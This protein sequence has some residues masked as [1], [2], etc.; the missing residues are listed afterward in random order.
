MNLAQALLPV[1]ESLPV[2]HAR[3]RWSFDLLNE[4]FGHFVQG[5]FRHRKED[6]QYLTPPEVVAAMIDIGLHDLVRDYRK[7]RSARKLLI[8]DP[9]C[10]VGSFLAGAY[11]QAGRQSFQGQALAERLEFFGQDK[12][13]RMVRMARVNMQCFSDAK[14][15]IRQGNSVDPE[16]LDDITGSVDLLLTNPPFGASFDRGKIVDGTKPDLAIG[17][18]RFPI[19]SE[20]QKQQT[21][22]ARIDSEFLMFDRSLSLLREGGRMLIVVPD[23]VV[24]ADGFAAAFRAATEEFAELIAVIDLPAEAFAQAGTRTKTSVVYVR[25]RQNPSLSAVSSNTAAGRFASPVFMATVNDLGFRVTSRAGASVKKQTGIN[26]L[27]AVVECYQKV[28]RCRTGSLKGSECKT[29]S[30]SPSVSLIVKSELLN[31]RW[32][33]SFY[34]A[35]R[36]GALAEIQQLDRRQWDLYTL[37]ELVS[38][39]PERDRRVDRSDGSAMI[40]V[41]HVREDGFLDLQ[42]VQ[43]YSPTSGCV[44]CQA[45]DVLISRINPRIVRICVVPDLGR[46][47]GCSPEFAVLRCGD[48]VDPWMLTLLLRGNLVQRQI[49]TLTSGTSSS[50]SRIKT[51]ELSSVIVPVPKVRHREF[52]QITRAAGE[53]RES[54]DTYYDAVRR[55][56]A[57]FAVVGS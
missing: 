47:I 48:Q 4:A 37:A 22:P 10:G 18:H 39:D 52:K 11:C 24:A 32:N 16:S 19:L 28:E 38:M 30:E 46:P 51:R 6:A 35:D 41:L 42:A 2:S 27:Q 43:Q 12:V 54:L 44:R 3:G 14:T 31:G 8:A 17:Q 21:L 57:C 23:K 29:R 1:V 33:A 20:L 56:L 50:H 49:Q 34:R 25:R 36:I 13:D 53:Y 26:E 7:D 15:L 55:T 45:H 40:S 5:S 9:T